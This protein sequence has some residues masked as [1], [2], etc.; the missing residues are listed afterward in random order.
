MEP[1]IPA[2]RTAVGPDVRAAVGSQEAKPIAFLGVDGR[3]GHEHGSGLCTEGDGHGS[4]A[5]GE[6]DGDGGEAGSRL[7]EAGSRLGPAVGSGQG[8]GQTMGQVQP[9]Q[10]RQLRLQT[11]P[12]ILGFSPES[13]AHTDRL[14]LQRR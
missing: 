1:A 5:G 12:E 7:G 2:V 10:Q 4:E 6:E 13:P 14:L 11:R 8:P 3:A 9:E